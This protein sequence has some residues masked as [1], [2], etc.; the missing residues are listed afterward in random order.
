MGMNS[1]ELPKFSSAGQIHRKG[2]V[3]QAAALCAR[4]KHPTRAVKRLRQ[5][6]TLGNVLCARLFTINVFSGIGG[7]N[8]GG[9]VPIWTGGD[10]DCINVAAGQQVAHVAI[11]RAVLVPVFRI[12]S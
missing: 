9:G 7:K 3:W 10:K 8:S 5:G 11:S 4:L 12:G 6:K 1:V 2:E